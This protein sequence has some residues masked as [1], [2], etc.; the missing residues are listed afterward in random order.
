MVTLLK[1]TLASSLELLSLIPCVDRDM[2]PGKGY[3][4]LCESGLSVCFLSGTCSLHPTGE[5]LEGLEQ[6]PGIGWDVDWGSLSKQVRT[7]QAFNVLP[8]FF[9]RSK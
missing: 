8:W 9:P 5:Q 3:L 7:P 4:C 2:H 6:M 1:I